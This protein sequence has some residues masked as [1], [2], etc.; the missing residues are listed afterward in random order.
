[1]GCYLYPLWNRTAGDCLLD[2]VLQATWGV[3]DRDGTLRRALA[4]SLV[5][6]ASLFY[7]RWKEEEQRQAHLQGYSLGEDQLRQDWAAV[8][9]LADQKRKSL[10]QIHVFALAHVLRRP[11]VV[12]GVKVV[13]NFRGEN[14]GFVNFEGVY[15]PLIWEK[16]FCSKSPVALAYTRGHF[17]ALVSLPS[18]QTNEVGAWSNRSCDSHVS[19][20][21]L[22]DS[23]G[24]QFPLHFISEEEIGCEERL[25]KQYC[26]C[27]VTKTGILTA[28]QEA[29]CP[30][31]LVSQLV[32]EWLD[33]Y[34]RMDKRR[35]A[36]ACSNY[37]SDS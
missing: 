27:H 8:L 28:V 18:S 7:K 2:S 3:M 19:Y 34:R 24:R 13:K 32:D 5:D 22:V 31:S 16:K 37:D 35:E 14:L 29:G 6:G 15:L 23:E 10:E 30:H 4:D 12:Y 9:A 33:R 20:L 21:P 1:M 25:L 11:V 26:E 36:A 17:S